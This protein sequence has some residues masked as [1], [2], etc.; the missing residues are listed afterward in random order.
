[1]ARIFAWCDSPEAGTGFGRSAKHV[2]GAFHEAGHEIVQLAVN[3]NGGPIPWQTMIPSNRANDPYGMADVGK[4][5]CTPG[6]FDAMWTTFDPECPWKYGIKNVDPPAS[7][8]QAATNLKRSN[9]GFRMMGWFPIDAGPLS[10]FELGVLGDRNVFDVA[11]TMSPHVKDLVRWTLRLRGQGGQVDDSEIEQRIKVIPHGIDMELYRPA[12]DKE[13]RAARERLGIPQDAFVILQLERNQQRKQVWLAYDLLERLFARDPKMRGRVVLYQHMFPNEEDG[14]SRVGWNLP[15]L[16]W[17]YGLVSPDRSGTSLA[18][19]VVWPEGQVAEDRLA[20]DVYG[21]ADCFLSVSAG[22]GFQY[23]AWEALAC[24]LPIVVPKDSAR[25]AW[26]QHAPGAHLYKTSEH[27]ILYRQA[28]NRRMAFPEIGDAVGIVHKLVRGKKKKHTAESAR[29]WIE[30]SG[31]TVAAVQERWLEV[32]DEQLVALDEQRKELKVAVTSLE[33]DFVI[34]ARQ[35]PGLGDLVMFAPAIAAFREK[36]AGKHVRLA[37]PRRHLELARIMEIADDYDVGGEEPP[38]DKRKNVSS[39]WHPKHREGW[40]DPAIHRTDVVARFLGVDPEDVR[41]LAIGGPDSGTAA[42]HFRIEFG[43]DPAS[44]VAVCLESG[45]EHRTLPRT[46]LPA[47][48]DGLR[49]MDL[50]PVLLGTQK[51]NCRRVGVV[52]LTGAMDL[53]ALLVM[54]DMAGMAICTDSLP[55]HLAG[56]LGTPLVACLPTFEPDARLR[57]YAG[58][59]EALTPPRDAA[60]NGER[61]PAGKAPRAP[62]GAWAA[63]ITVPMIL[64]AARRLAGADEAPRVVEPGSLED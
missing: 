3:Y 16:T 53:P 50:V 33:P 56:A 17:R 22:E 34:D 41:P 58:A 5:F 7:A 4:V 25:K 31:A 24:G 42:N 21:A 14:G 32:L 9:P 28:Y 6:R 52:D 13:R 54:I 26:L 61:F 44:C 10:D 2:L 18:A 36:H 49:E 20:P 38:S 37:I 19:D 8:L 27:G 55:M 47:L 45:N 15:E 57:Y 60:I 23:P 12:T 62:A 1:M 35:E 63:H 11:A 39:L 59:I 30:R 43:A 40:S 46:I 64:A 51:L 29:N 48:C